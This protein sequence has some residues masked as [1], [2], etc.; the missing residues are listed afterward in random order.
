MT[1]NVAEEEERREKREVG[2]KG[3]SFI[4]SAHT[5]LLL[6]S[7]RKDKVEKE[8]SGAETNGSEF[9]RDEQRQRQ[10]VAGKGRER[11]KE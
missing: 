5:F 3:R 1:F 8:R 4:T 9:K 6:I 11:W 10:R 2:R 7:V